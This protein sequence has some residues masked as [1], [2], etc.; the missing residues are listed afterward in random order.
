MI[1]A[2]ALI[3]VVVTAVYLSPVFQ[4]F[5]GGSTEP[6]TVGFE[7][8]ESN[9]ATTITISP[10]KTDLAWDHWTFIIGLRSVTLNGDSATLETTEWRPLSEDL[11]EGAPTAV[12]L[13]E[14][15][16]GDG[17]I[18]CVATDAAGDGI[19]EPGDYL[20]ITGTPGLYNI[21]AFDEAAGSEASSVYDF[22]LYS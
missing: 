17:A 2:A 6:V 12:D 9:D 11:D 19:L 20:T 8:V 18:R 15:S 5:S 1:C 14:Q 7:M 13:G 10:V 22:V 21:L 3:A 16:L 4:G